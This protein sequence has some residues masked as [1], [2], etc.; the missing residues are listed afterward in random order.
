MSRS[1]DTKQAR[2]SEPGASLPASDP[3]RK[4]SPWYAQLFPEQ[5]R[6]AD[7]II[8]RPASALFCKPGVGKT[9]LAM[10][11]LEAT[12]WRLALIVAPL[13]SLDVTWHPKLVTLPDTIINKELVSSLK[14]LGR[15]HPRQIIL[16]NPEAL[17]RSLKGNRIGKLPWDVVIWDES[18]N[19]KNRSSINSRLARRLRHVPRRLALSGTPMDTGQIDIWAQMRFVDHTVFGESWREFANEYCYK[20]GWMGKEWKFSPKKNDDFVRLLE[21]YVMRL[22]DDFL[23]LEPIRVVPVPTLLLGEQRRIYEAMQHHSIVDL[24][25]NIGDGLVTANNEGARDVKLSQIT[26]GAVLDA[27]GLVHPTGR[28]KARKLAHLLRGLERPVVVFCQYLHEIDIIRELV[29]QAQVIRGGTSTKH[30]TKV[31]ADFQA[32]H[33]PELVCQIRTAG[34]SISLTRAATMIMYSMTYSYI[35]FEQVLRRLQRGGQTRPVT[36]YIIFCPST[37]DED[38]LSLVQDKSE[39]SLRVL[40]HFEE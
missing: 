1:N 25:D 20:T 16:T 9:Y 13:T 21:P 23:G 22:G 18:Q 24:A 37:I 4:P 14:S 17:R 28:A 11:M 10:A 34:E 31:I 15:S 19:I 5:R 6:A 40:A 38:K 32:G 7:F 26:G 30:R 3:P 2:S 36:A 8:S 29:P 27:D 39:T 33:I 12:S 35:N